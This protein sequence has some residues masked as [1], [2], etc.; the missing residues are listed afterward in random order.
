[1]NRNEKKIFECK[2]RF[3]Y[4]R[5]FRKENGIFC[6]IDEAGRG[7]WI[8]SVYAAAVVLDDD[9]YIEDLNDSKKLSESRREELYEE[10]TEKAVSWSVAYAGV[11][12]IEELNILGATFLAMNRAVKGLSPTP[13]YVLADGNR[14][15]KLDFDIKIRTLVKG[16]GISAS[17]A[18]ASILAKVARDKYM[19]ELDKRYPEFGFASNKGYGTARH[20]EALIKY[21]FTPE[22]RKLF[23]RKLTKKIGE[24]LKEYKEIT[25]K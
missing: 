18:A 16:D 10:I 1:M 13:E 11:E 7:P 17:V 14:E 5:T 9:V 8:G 25:H 6:G 21:G 24:P 2:K 22:H 23:L 3:E 19:K 15:P 20:E 12:E 4:D